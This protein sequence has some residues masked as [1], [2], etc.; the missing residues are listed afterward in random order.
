MLLVE[1]PWR[2][3]DSAWGQRQ[4]RWP[5]NLDK[6]RTSVVFLGV[7]ARPALRERAAVH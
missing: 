1:V 2:E 7:F 5:A 3:N 4:P 6:S